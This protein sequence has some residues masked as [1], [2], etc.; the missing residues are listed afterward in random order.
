MKTVIQFVYSVLLKKQPLFLFSDGYFLVAGS[1]ETGS[2]RGSVPVHGAAT[3]A[4]PCNFTDQ[5]HV[6]TA[7]S[8]STV[9]AH[10]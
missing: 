3:E 7:S 2:Q 4:I 6:Q 8:C 1:A 10:T 5:E 9:S